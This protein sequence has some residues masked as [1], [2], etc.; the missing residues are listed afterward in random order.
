MFSTA[1]PRQDEFQADAKTNMIYNRNENADGKRNQQTQ[2]CEHDC[3][4]LLN[5]FQIKKKR[6][7]VLLNY[8]HIVW[9]QMDVKHCRSS[10]NISSHEKTPVTGATAANK[11]S[12]NT[13]AAQKG[14]IHN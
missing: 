2:Q 10:K 3:D 12:A 14:T 9:E 5:N 13:D 7:K 1:P 11:P 4:I 6:Y 8:D